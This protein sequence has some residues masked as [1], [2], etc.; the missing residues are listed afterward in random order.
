MNFYYVTLIFVVICLLVL[1]RLEA[2]RLVYK[3]D[4]SIRQNK[5]LATSVGVFSAKYKLW[6]FVLSCGFAGAVGSFLAH[7]YNYIDPATHTSGMN[8]LRYVIIGGRDS[9]AGPIVGAIFLPFITEYFRAFQRYSSAV[10]SVVL[11]IFIIYIPNGLMSI[12]GRL[13]RRFGKS[14]RKT[15]IPPQWI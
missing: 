13:K 14:E 8:F 15:F 1:W 7:Y 9:F 2:G 12:P 4:H 6:N 10:L 5:K 3:T 11:I